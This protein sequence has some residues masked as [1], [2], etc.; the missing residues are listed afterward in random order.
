MS[1]QRDDKIV[2]KLQHADLNGFPQYEAISYVWGDATIRRTIT[3]D[4]CA[5]KVTV[6][7]FLTLQRFINQI[8][9]GS[10]G[11]TLYA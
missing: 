2:C 11:Q 7:L 8:I 10:Y 9:H 4:C 3:R 1:G 6:N 5:F